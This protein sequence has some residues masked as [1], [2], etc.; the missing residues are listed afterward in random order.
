[1]GDEEVRQWMC[2]GRCCLWTEKS[3]R[4][5]AKVSAFW[6]PY[7]E[8]FVFMKNGMCLLNEEFFVFN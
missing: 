8:K 4:H 7:F 2:L 1:M 5:Q 3:R 6:A